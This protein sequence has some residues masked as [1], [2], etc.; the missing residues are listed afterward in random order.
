MRT[1]REEKTVVLC[2]DID[3]TICKTEFG[4]YSESTPY[5]D[6]IKIINEAYDRGHSIIY[7]TGRHWNSLR[8]TVDQLAKWGCKYHTLSMGKPPADLYIDDKAIE[9]GA[10]FVI[11]N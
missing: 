7:F 2:I 6:R 1:L 5:R 8:L 11:K 10:Y 3:G 4:N 9:A